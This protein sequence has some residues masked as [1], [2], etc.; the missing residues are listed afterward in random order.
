MYYTQY[1][2]RERER[3]KHEEQAGFEFGSG[4]TRCE[5]NV[6]CRMAADGARGGASGGS[7]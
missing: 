1:S 7:V 2:G 4:E 5:E 3:E 6:H